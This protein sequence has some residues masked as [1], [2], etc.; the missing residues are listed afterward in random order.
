MQRFRSSIYGKMQASG[1]AEIVSFICI[2]LSEANFFFIIRKLLLL[3]CPTLCDPMNCGTPG[4]PVIH[5]LPE[6]A[7]I[8]VS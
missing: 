3:S 5:Y 2:Y 8:H 4:F 6:S 7:Q 1:L